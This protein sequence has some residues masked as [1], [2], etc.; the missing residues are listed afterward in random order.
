M[1]PL[2]CRLSVGRIVY[3]TSAS[4][5]EKSAGGFNLSGRGWFC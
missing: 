5:A 3:I 2:G 4:G 1:R